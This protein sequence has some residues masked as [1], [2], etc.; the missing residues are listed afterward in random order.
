M[1]LP[2]QIEREISL[3]EA[4]Y[5]ARRGQ[6]AGYP[7]LRGLRSVIEDFMREAGVNWEGKRPPPAH[8]ERPK[9]YVEE[10]DL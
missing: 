5:A 9:F 8:R 6:Q 1:R 4:E 10:G 7:R 3:I 2:P